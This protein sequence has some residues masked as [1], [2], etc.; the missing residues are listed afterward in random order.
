MNGAAYSLF[1]FNLLNPDYAL[2]KKNDLSFCL[3]ISKRP[4]NHFRFSPIADMFKIV[5][6]ACLLIQL[7]NAKH[8]NL[9]VLKVAWD[10][11][12]RTS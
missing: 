1:F 7:P 8:L 6:P 4:S 11:D 3:T 12:L 5:F 2:E 10:L 9:N